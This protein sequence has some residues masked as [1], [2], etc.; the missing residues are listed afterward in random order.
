MLAAAVASLLALNAPVSGQS[1]PKP[2]GWGA[3]TMLEPIIAAHGGFSALCNPRAGAL[4]T[5]GVD[6]IDKLV[7]PDG[8]QRAALD[9]LRAA[10]VKATDLGSAACPREIP[11]GS[12]ER[13]AFAEQRLAA[14]LQAVKMVGPAFDAFHALLSDQQKAKLD[15][16]PGRWR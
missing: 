15:A 2:S 8:P 5:R 14:L 16:G 12:R 1:L 7:A 13:L 10:A 9:A 11:R 3:K 6:Q 4:A